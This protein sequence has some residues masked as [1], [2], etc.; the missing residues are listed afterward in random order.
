MLVNSDMDNAGSW[1][2]YSILPVGTGLT[3]SI[4]LVPCASLQFHMPSERW[5]RF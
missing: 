1:T 3:L 2:A 5:R 4:S